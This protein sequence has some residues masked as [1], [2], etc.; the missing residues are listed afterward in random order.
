MIDFIFCSVSSDGRSLFAG[1]W[2]LVSVLIVLH[3]DDMAALFPARS[4][5]KQKQSWLPSQ[6]SWHVSLR[7]RCCLYSTNFFCCLHLSFSN[8]ACFIPV[9]SHGRRVWYFS[10][11]F[12]RGP[13]LLITFKNKSIQY[14]SVTLG[15]LKLYTFSKG[16]TC[17]PWKKLF[18]QTETSVNNWRVDVQNRLYNF[19]RQGTAHWKMIAYSCGRH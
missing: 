5:K 17:K 16:I 19:D 18:H 1:L 14:D 12:S 11:F 7:F 10:R 13:R 15:S 3:M 4:L 6:G 2:P 8:M 9:F